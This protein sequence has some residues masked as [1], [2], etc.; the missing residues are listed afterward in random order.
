MDTNILYKQKFKANKLY[1]Y[2][3]Y[4]EDMYL[5]D[6]KPDDNFM[7]MLPFSEYV[8]VR[9][10]NINANYVEGN[11]SIVPQLLRKLRELNYNILFL[12]RYEHDKMYAKGI[13][14]IYIPNGA[15]NG[16]DAC[17]YS[18][19]VL[20]GAGTMARE[21]ACLGVP[22][23]SFFAGSKLL[24]VDRKLIE[25]GKMFFSRKVDDIV[26]YLDSA[27]RIKS[28]LTRCKDVQNEILSKLDEVLKAYFARL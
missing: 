28:D 11:I 9:P 20:T 14:N 7:N 15:L 25:E 19:A 12:P 23:V 17:Y 13:D 2:N 8:V 3:G 16:M 1:Q 18:Q 22:S 24:T 21:A 4:K 10:E 5:A 6:Y 27:K 26:Q